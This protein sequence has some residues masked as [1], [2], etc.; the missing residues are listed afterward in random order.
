[1]FTENKNYYPTPLKLISK[2]LEG[3]ELRSFRT[4][5]EPS[6]GRGDIV[7]YI[8]KRLGN[9]NMKYCNIDCIEKDISLQ[10]ILKG[11][12]YK[13]V[14]DDFLS[15]TTYKRY[16]LIVMN[17]P[18]DN[19]DKHLL[20]AL[21]LQQ[22]GGKIICLLNAETIKNPYSNTRKDLITKLKAHNAEIEFIDNAFSEADRKTDVEI[23][24]IKVNIKNNRKD[25]VI[26]D[27]LKQE[28]QYKTAN[29]ETGEIITGDFIDRIIQQYNFEIKAGV[30]LINEYLSIKPMLSRSFDDK[31]SILELSIYDDKYSKD[32]ALVNEFIKR[33]R[34]K[35]WSTLFQSKDFAKLMTTDLHSQYMEKINELQEY[36]FS[37]YNIEQIKLDMSIAMKDSLEQTILNLFD[38]FIKYSYSDEYK[39]N[40]YLYNGWKSNSAYKINDDKLI[41]PLSAYDYWDGR[42]YP[43]D[44]RF[45]RKLRD[46]EKV[47][48]YLDSGR[49]QTED[50]LDEIL[51]EA[52]E[53][54]Q[55]KDIDCKYFILRCYKKGTTH[56]LWKDKDLVNKLN[57]FGSQK[58]GW[59]P[60]S[61]GKYKYD[62]MT[63]EE[64]DVIDSFQG[65][66][67]YNKIFDNKDLYLYDSSKLLA[68]GE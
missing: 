2:M 47:F 20:K 8:E 61:Y 31:W 19:G 17:P 36:D 33:V 51:Q 63:K 35:Y 25:S 3:V 54:G 37:K 29:T 53:K 16:D 39:H 52:R 46:I 9:D 55:T 21:E 26:I 48:N 57:I 6:A 45:K 62:E 15:F 44:Y 41:L 66:E 10:H 12:G 38:D 28:E 30:Q 7:K 14:H 64:K 40:I 23:A 56:F 27:H 34:Y 1:M 18:F 50:D 43:T 22:N 11:E 68:L 67:E 4:I 65:K 59:L 42:F 24:L 58:K 60:P 5:L 32:E 49:T 13:V